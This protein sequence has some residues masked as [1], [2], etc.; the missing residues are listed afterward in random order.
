MRFISLLIT[1]LVIY[2]LGGGHTHTHTHTHIHTHTND[3]YRIRCTWFN[4]IITT[5][6]YLLRG[7]TQRTSASVYMYF[8]S[9]FKILSNVL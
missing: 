5:H 3:P 9:L 2:S 4:T 7:C 1:P 6:S 8:I